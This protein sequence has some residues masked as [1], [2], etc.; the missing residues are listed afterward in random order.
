M[1]KIDPHNRAE[2]FEEWKRK[3]IND[4]SSINAQHLRDFI[5][6]LE[7]GLNVGGSKGSRGAARLLANISQIKRVMKAAE[8]HYKI[9]D[10]TKID[11]KTLHKIFLDIQQGKI[12]KDNGK[13]YTFIGDLVK[14][15]KTFWHWWVKANK[16][17]GI[18]IPDITEDL[19]GESTKQTKFVYFTNEQLEKMLELA[20]YDTKT[21]MLFLFDT[22]IR[23]PTEC[24]NIRASDFIDDYKQLN[25]RN[26]IAK[27]FGRQ[28]RLMMCSEAIQQYIE[29]NHY[30]DDDLIFPFEPATINKRLGK[31]GK[32][33]LGE[34]TT[35]GRKKGSDLT[36][37]DFRHSSCCYWLPRYKSRNAILYRF[38]WKKENELHYYSDLLGMTDTISEEDMLITSTRTD[39]EKDVIKLK[40]DFKEL[41]DKS[42]EF[43]LQAIENSKRQ[44]E[45]INQTREILNLY[46]KLNI[47]PLPDAK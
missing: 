36:M 39:L 15:F 42:K 19:K 16:K 14:R 44:E 37:Y 35:L 45:L 26:E 4:I 6:D 28:I 47:K 7:S 43:T 29:K 8:K 18:I 24:F 32:Q 30:K 33:I 34:K 10:I 27:T 1:Q 31:I 46:K 3:E 13:P 38:G 25:I 5:S 23:A 41:K 12:T 22:G 9:K 21:L 11:E 2:H 40:R 20:D 17:K